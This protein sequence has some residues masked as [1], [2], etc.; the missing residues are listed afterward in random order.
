M[1]TGKN[2]T[3]VST[4]PANIHVPL[5]TED[6][7]AGTVE[8]P[9]QSLGNYCKALEDGKIAIK[10]GV[11]LVAQ[12]GSTIQ[13]DA[14]AALVSNGLAEFHGVGANRTVIDECS[15]ANATNIDVNNLDINVSCDVESGVTVTVKSGATLSCPAGSMVLLGGR[16]RGRQRVQLSD[17]DHSVGPA[18]GT[19]FELAAP[20]FVSRVITL[21]SV[22]GQTA[23]NEEVLE[24]FMPSMITGGSVTGS[25][26]F[27]RESGAIVAKIVSDGVH[28]GSVSA[29]FEFSS[30]V[31]RL[32]LN[33]GYDFNDSIGVVTFAGVS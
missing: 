12:S 5:A 9:F 2:L 10:T 27:R 4:V 17:A 18:D 31:W 29:Q 1:T 25:Y 15:I 16:T 6:V 33:S 21:L 8:I 3:L 11:T 7:D 13:L 14:D 32:W 19:R 23:Q 30:G 28:A 24:F 26:E 22:T 20:T